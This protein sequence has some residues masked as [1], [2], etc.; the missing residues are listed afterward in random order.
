MSHNLLLYLIIEDDEDDLE[1]KNSSSC[2]LACRA[3]KRALDTSEG[4]S[5][6]CKH[7]TIN[8]HHSQGIKSTVKYFTEI[9]KV[10]RV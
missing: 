6:F 7:L 4:N 1:T 8:L 3:T 10:R 5:E 2:T 9:Q